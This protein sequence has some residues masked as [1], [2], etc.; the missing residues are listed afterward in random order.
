VH[1]VRAK[2]LQNVL[3]SI[4]TGIPAVHFFEKR[5]SDLGR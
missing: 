2:A 4:Q 1:I 5:A 3:Y